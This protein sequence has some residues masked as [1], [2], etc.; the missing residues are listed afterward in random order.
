M[1]KTELFW[2]CLLGVVIGALIPRFVV[3]V[4]VQYCRPNDVQIAREMEKFENLRESQDT[5]LE[6]NQIFDPPRR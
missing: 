2:L 4:F 5:Q 1:A 6:M 3:K